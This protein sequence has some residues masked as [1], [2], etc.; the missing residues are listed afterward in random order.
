[1]F[2]PPGAERASLCG[3]LLSCFQ[4]EK[5]SHGAF[6]TPVVFQVSLAQNSQYAKSAYFGRACPEPLHLSCLSK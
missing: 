3:S 4:E 1:M 6:L 2:F 5:G